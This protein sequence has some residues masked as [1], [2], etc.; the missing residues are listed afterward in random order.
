MKINTLPRAEFIKKIWDLNPGESV[1]YYEEY[2]GLDQTGA[3]VI[4]KFTYNGILMYVGI[5]YGGSWPFFFV[6]DQKDL[7]NEERRFQ[8]EYDAHLDYGFADEIYMNAACPTV[9][10]RN[11]ENPTIGALIGMDSNVKGSANRLYL[12]RRAWLLLDGEQLFFSINRDD[13]TIKSFRLGDCPMFI[14]ANTDGKISFDKEKVY[15]F[16]YDPAEWEDDSKKDFYETFLPY[17]KG[18]NSDEAFS[19]DVNRSYMGDAEFDN[20]DVGEI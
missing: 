5:Y 12:A 17:L 13:F 10:V 19:I 6:V 16:A 18:I 11:L 8:Q 4:K 20:A 1:D 15:F 3:R 7:A 2:D 9:G 14:C